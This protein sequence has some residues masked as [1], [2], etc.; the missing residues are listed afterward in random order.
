MR[1]LRPKN[2]AKEKE[3]RKKARAVNNGKPTSDLPFIVFLI[4]MMLIAIS[5]M[6]LFSTIPHFYKFGCG[7]SELEI[8][9]LMALNGIA[10]FVLEMPIIRKFESDK[11]SVYKILIISTWLMALSFFVLTFSNHLG[12]LILS[13][14]LITFGEVFNFPFGNSWAMNR[15]EGKRQGAYM[16][17][18]TIS[19]AISNIVCHNLGMQLIDRYGYYVTWY[20][21]TGILVVAVGFLMWMKR[22]VEAE[23]AVKEASD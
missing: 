7:M 21:M 4:A 2:P 8:G 5:F 16:G 10:L 11:Y 12:I 23:D 15:A 14:A 20:V 3:D 13:M 9:L 22:L 17:L 6:Q 1:T 18:Y 19:F